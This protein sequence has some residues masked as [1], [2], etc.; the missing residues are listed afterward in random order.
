MPNDTP[1]GTV[2]NSLVG[3]SVP[4]MSDVL[5][6]FFLL[7]TGI[8]KGLAAAGDI[9]KDVL[10]GSNKHLEQKYCPSWAIITP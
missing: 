6:G 1:D 8:E 5:I 3:I 10:A 4:K 2:N 7:T 9:T